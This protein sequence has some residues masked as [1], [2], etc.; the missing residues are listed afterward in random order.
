[1]Y[2]PFACGVTQTIDGFGVAISEGFPGVFA[3]APSTEQGS[4]LLPVQIE[5]K[6]GDPIQLCA[7]I[8]ST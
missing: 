7:P 6:P 3:I 5:P 2:A 8:H 1:M 4:D